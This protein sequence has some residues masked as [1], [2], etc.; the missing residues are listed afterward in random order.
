M[1]GPTNIIVL[2]DR[3]SISQLMD[4]KGAIYS[5]R[6]Q[7]YVTQFMTGGDHLT[8]GTPRPIL[9]N[10]TFNFISVFYSEAIG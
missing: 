8:L 9:E 1:I 3:K 10:E 5:D 2:C 6:P 7:H 4:K